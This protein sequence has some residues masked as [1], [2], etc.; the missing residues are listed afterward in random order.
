MSSSKPVDAST[1]DEYVARL[2]EP[3]HSQIRR[4][5]NLIRETVPELEP[6]MRSGMIG[7]GSYHYKY[8]TGREGD[9]FIIGLASN[10]NYISLYVVGTDGDEY[11]AE[12]YRDRLPKTSIGKSCVRF[13]RL[14]D[15]DPAV[16]IQLIRDGAACFD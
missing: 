14:E 7:F 16:I 12:R 13:K 6:H 15:V 1:P 3:R 9:W 2:D 11:V 5:Y 4:L 8:P 10:K